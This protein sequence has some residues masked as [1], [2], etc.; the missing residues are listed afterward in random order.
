GGPE[1][2]STEVSCERRGN[3]EAL[4]PPLGAELTTGEHALQARLRGAPP[5]LLELIR[6]LGRADLVKFARARTTPAE[7]YADLEAARRWVEQH[8]AVSPRTSGVEVAA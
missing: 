7:A 3:L 8:D 6:I 4:E 5:V 2:C 1:R